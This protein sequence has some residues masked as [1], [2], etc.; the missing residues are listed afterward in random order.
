LNPI[1]NP[2]RKIVRFKEEPSW[3]KKKKLN[4][5]DLNFMPNPQYLL[6]RGVDQYLEID[7]DSTQ[8]QDTE[9]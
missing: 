8:S 9:K 7:A 3:K 2:H 5:A 6:D 1:I 4:P